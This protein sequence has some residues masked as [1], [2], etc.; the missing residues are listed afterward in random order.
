[1]IRYLIT[2]LRH[3]GL[4]APNQSVNPGVGLLVP[5][6]SVGPVLPSIFSLMMGTLC[7]SCNPPNIPYFSINIHPHSEDPRLHLYC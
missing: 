5:E 6:A 2:A 1:M 4:G 7:R 3:S